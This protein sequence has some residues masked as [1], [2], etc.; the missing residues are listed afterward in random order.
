MV[1]DDIDFKTMESL[2]EGLDVDLLVGNS[3][4]YKIA[5][6][7]DVPLIRVGLPVHDRLGAARIRTLGYGG[8]QQLYDRIVNA[9]IQRQQDESPV[10][11]THI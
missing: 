10:G 11:Y 6:G 1:R 9:F 3:N 4:G 7:L 5:R 8:I 2:I